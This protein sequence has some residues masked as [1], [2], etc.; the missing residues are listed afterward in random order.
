M[1]CMGGSSPQTRVTGDNLPLP[2]TFKGVN[3]MS[4]FIGVVVALSVIFMSVFTFGHAVNNKAFCD[5]EYEPGLCRMLST[6]PAS[7]AWPLYWSYE[8]QRKD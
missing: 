4:D 5:I 2:P 7:I 8:L 3:L 1:N 6:I